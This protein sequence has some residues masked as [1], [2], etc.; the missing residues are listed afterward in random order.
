MSLWETLQHEAVFRRVL[1]GVLGAMLGSFASAAIYRIPREGL[2]VWRPMRSFCPSCKAQIKWHDNLPILGYLI[3]RGRCRSCKVGYGPGY[4]VHE[5]VLAGLFVLAGETWLVSQQAAPTALLFALVALT[6]LWIATAIDWEHLIL[7]DGITLGGIPF[8]IAAAVLAPSFHLGAGLDHLPWG[9]DWLGISLADPQTK[10]VLVSAILGSSIS[11]ALLIGIRVLFSYIL[12][13]E[14]LGLGDV[15]YLAAI[16]AFLG[17]EGAA[18]TLLIGVFAGAVL[19]LL[20]IVRMIWVVAHRRRQRGRTR[21]LKSSV[22]MGWLLGRLFPF[23]P[24]LVL[25]TVLYLLYPEDIR[26]FFLETWP[27]LLLH[28]D[29]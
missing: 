22:Y 24:P 5:I 14:A 27:N 19:G 28:A 23:G 1:L 26:V 12:R 21:V 18:W 15:K 10:I 4:M 25:G 2:S 29:S 17:L 7:P 6:A 11:W 8:G 13:Q 3:L 20:N 9:V 16:G